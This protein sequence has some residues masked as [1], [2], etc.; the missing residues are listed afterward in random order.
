MD[1]SRKEKQ[2][3]DLVIFYNIMFVSCYGDVIIVSTNSC[4]NDAFEAV[5]ICIC[6]KK[7]K[8]TNK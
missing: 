8:F 2:W 3:D 1:L 4:H 7:I 6:G 5:F